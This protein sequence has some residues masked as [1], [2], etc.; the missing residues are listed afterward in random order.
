MLT[1]ACGQSK[2]VAMRLI[3]AFTVGIL[4][5]AA[6]ASPQAADACRAGP[7]TLNFVTK[8]PPPVF[9]NR[10]NVAGIRNLFVMRGQTLAGPHQRA[11]GV[12]FAQTILS[13]SGQST[14]RQEGRIYCVNLDKV[15]ADFGWDRMEVYVASEFKPGECAYNAVL[16]HENQHVAINQAALREFA[17]RVRQALENALR[18]QRPLAVANPQGGAD[19]LL[20]SVH[21]RMNAMLDEFQRALAERNAVI[22]TNSNYDAIAA[23]CPDWKRPVPAQ[24]AR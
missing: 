23:L 12:T 10:L 19:T 2:M 3:L 8:T 20:A 16:D 24:P 18:E 9:N 13:L 5:V 21:A 11:L 17:P 14:A 1:L 22:D 7:I 4:V 15:D 6:T